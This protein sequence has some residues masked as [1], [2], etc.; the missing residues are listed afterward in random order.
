MVR[1]QTEDG[2]TKADKADAIAAL[3]AEVTALSPKARAVQLPR[4]I[5]ALAEALK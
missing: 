3:I 5:R 4:I 2:I 1:K